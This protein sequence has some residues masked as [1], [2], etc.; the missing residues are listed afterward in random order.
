M[1]I[2]EVVNN[3]SAPAMQSYEDL[4][5]IASEIWTRDAEDIDLWHGPHGVIINT[6]ALHA[7][8]FYYDL[9]LKED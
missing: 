2:F 6:A 9:I 3:D 1:N 4:P 5:K 8:K 7:R